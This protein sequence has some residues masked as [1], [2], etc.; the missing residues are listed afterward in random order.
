[1]I[2]QPDQQGPDGRRMLIL[3]REWRDDF[4]GEALT[5]TVDAAG[6]AERIEFY[7][8]SDGVVSWVAG[9]GLGTPRRWEG[10]GALSDANAHARHFPALLL[11]GATGDLTALAIVDA[12][13]RQVAH[14]PLVAWLRAALAEPQLR[15][16]P[17]AAIPPP[18]AREPTAPTR[19]RR[20]V[21]D[22]M[23][24]YTAWSKP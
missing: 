9:H 23:R 1:M 8:A 11:D 10:E 13:L 21:L 17:E 22:L 12:V 14:P 7:S 5:I 20:S 4:V 15:H 3:Q 2:R 18:P 19:R 24:D 16:R 6:V